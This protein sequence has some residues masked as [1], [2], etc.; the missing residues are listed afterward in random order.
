MSDVET[1]VVV[2]TLLA[3]RLT[4]VEIEKLG[5]ILAKVQAWTLVNTLSDWVENKNKETLR[6][7][8]YEVEAK[9]FVYTLVD[10]LAQVEV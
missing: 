4:E 7:E 2:Y 8:L 9:A 3:Y 10:R 5:E 1:K 6:E